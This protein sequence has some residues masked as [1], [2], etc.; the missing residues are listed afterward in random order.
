MALDRRDFL[1]QA[2]AAAFLIGFSSLRRLPGQDEPLRSPI[3]DALGQMRRRRSHGVAILLPE[4]PEDRERLAGALE[5]LVRRADSDD[6]EAQ[7]I[8]LEA[9]YVCA[10][11]AA[12]DAR[13]GEGAVLL[14]FSGKR[15]AGIPLDPDALA[16]GIRGLLH[17]EGR[18]EARAKA[19][20]TPEARD[21]FRGIRSGDAE[22]QQ[23]SYALL[24]DSFDSL[25]PAIVAERIREES[26]GTLSP[27]RAL[28]RRAFLLRSFTP[29]APEVVH[30]VVWKKEDLPDPC[31]PCGMALV[32]RVS[33]KFLRF[34]TE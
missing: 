21:A 5:A 10:A 25:V 27:L 8:L 33:R 28:A 2:G 11:P 14:D 20:L 23:R 6:Y 31:P 18:L 24:H 19:V 26:D 16:A 3:L 30:G 4:R 32:P 17:G 9:V 29:D 34:L 1:R 7:E 22:E 12:V 15:V 13:P